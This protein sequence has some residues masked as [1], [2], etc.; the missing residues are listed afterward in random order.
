LAF[1]LMMCAYSLRTWRRNGIACDEL[2]FLPGTLHGHEHGVEGPLIEM[3]EQ[4]QQ[5]QQQPASP[6]EQI[7][8]QQA[9]PNSNSHLQSQAMQRS[10]SSPIRKS[11]TKS[12]A[13]L[14]AGGARGPS[15]PAFRKRRAH[16]EDEAGLV[17]I[18][19]SASVDGES[20]SSL[21]ETT[22]NNTLNTDEEPGSWDIEVE[23][24]EHQ[25]TI[26]RL[27]KM[28]PIFSLLAPVQSNDGG[29]ITHAS[30]YWGPFSFFD[31]RLRRHRVLL[32]HHRAR[33]YSEQALT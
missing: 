28:P 1:T 24:D 23:E 30:L 2:L 6:S 3:P 29:K 22:E 17:A 10:S 12:E 31:P 7:L 32:T 19:N 21:Q 4:Q 5:Q 33:Q 20:S 26:L 18:E 15:P 27:P 11:Q 14:A 13:D 9:S 8:S 25:R 16:S